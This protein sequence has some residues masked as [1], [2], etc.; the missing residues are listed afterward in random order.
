M[1]AQ[2]LAIFVAAVIGAI[3]G[4]LYLIVP[5]NEVS[6]LNNWLDKFVQAGKRAFAGA[7]AGAIFSPGLYVVVKANGWQLDW[8]LLAVLISIMSAGYFGI[9]IVKAVLQKPETV[10]GIGRG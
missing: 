7:I 8:T 3:G 5:P 6:V 4:L 10:P 1:N 2:M 9:D